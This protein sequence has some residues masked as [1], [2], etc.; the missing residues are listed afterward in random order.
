M[1]LGRLS[2]VFLVALGLVACS[3]PVG[4]ATLARQAALGM[5]IEYQAVR[6]ADRVLTDAVDCSASPEDNATAIAALVDGTLG[7]CGEVTASGAGVDVVT[8]AS[9]E[10]GHDTIAS[11]AS[12]LDVSRDADELVFAFELPRARINGLD[13]VGTMTLRT[14]DCAS[15]RTTMDLASNEYT[16]A[17][18][19]GDA[20]DVRLSPSGTGIDGVL[21][22]VALNGLAGARELSVANDAL[23]FEVGDCWPRGGSLQG[24]RATTTV[25]LAFDAT[26]V[27]LGI[28]RVVPAVA[29]ASA[30]ELPQYGP[31]PDQIP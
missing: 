15:F 26:T 31:C 23:A 11:L 9:C 25:T 14:S 5:T 27:E 8:G 7:G 20:L 18:H 22:V 13:A 19:D 6:F 24:V 12:H 29:G 17:T 3:E 10:F 30:Y 1:Q 4:D 21:D 2:S 28:A 16:I